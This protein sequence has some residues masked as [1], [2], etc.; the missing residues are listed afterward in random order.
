[1]Y[2]TKNTEAMVKDQNL[3]PAHQS[4]NSSIETFG[5]DMLTENLGFDAKV[6]PDEAFFAVVFDKRMM[7]KKAV[8]EATG[9]S[10]RQYERVFHDR[11]ERWRGLNTGF[12]ANKVMS[13]HL[14]R[15]D[16]EPHQVAMSELLW[17]LMKRFA[18]QEI[19]DQLWIMTGRSLE[20]DYPQDKDFDMSN[21]HITP[22]ELN[23]AICL[24]FL[25]YCESTD[26][27]SETC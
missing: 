21:F 16:L 14:E 15:E 22:E 12:E 26:Q 3:T 18:M 27:E 8:Q 5:L 25:H 6:C 7:S 19:L 24:H 2:N 23:E 20:E 13:N 17:K 4:E 1:M 11:N 9:L 10:R